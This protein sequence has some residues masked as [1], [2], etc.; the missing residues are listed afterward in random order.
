MGGALAFA[1][2]AESITYTTVALEGDLAPGTGGGF[3]TFSAPLVNDAGEVV[4]T[5]SA[6]DFNEQGIWIAGGGVIGNVMLTGTSA[7]GTSLTFST[8][9]RN[10]KIANDGD[11]G[12]YHRVVDPQD[13]FDSLWRG[14][15]G[16]Y[17]VVAL[18]DDGDTLFSALSDQLMMFDDGSNAFRGFTPGVV[19]GIY[20]SPAGSGVPTLVAEEGTIAPG[21]SVAF[22]EIFSPAAANEVGGVLFNGELDAASGV[23]RGVWHATSA[24]ALLLVREGDP[25]PGLGGPVHRTFSSLMIADTGEAGFVFATDGSPPVRGIMAGMPGNLSVRLQT[26]DAAPVPGEPDAVFDIFGDAQT[27]GSGDIAFVS[28]VDG[29]N[30][31]AFDDEM[32]FAIVDDAVSLAARTGDPAP[33][34]GGATFTRLV[35]PLINDLG[36]VVFTAE[37]TGA[38][39]GIWALHGDGLE[40]VVQEGDLFDVG[41]GDVRE[42]ETI[43]FHA[44]AGTQQAA[45]GDAGHLAFQLYFT[46][47]TSGIFT[48]RLTPVPEPGPW[49]AQLAALGLVA[50]IRV[51]AQSSR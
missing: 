32:L 4:F 21:T 7:P 11:A 12:A 24:G 50:C 25:V 29:M 36:Q 14:S 2:P 28:T 23:D 3:T 46:D 1:L 19:R 45:F 18:D 38:G 20:F 9:R 40:S 17:A 10:V 48:A 47:D 44:A 13:G 5:G 30:I 49:L 33:G 51:F 26:G 39:T 42:V 27:S 37:T 43:A 6:N 16:D 22:M 35:D 41:G 31:T 8:T 15:P 34:G